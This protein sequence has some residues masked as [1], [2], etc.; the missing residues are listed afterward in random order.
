M[1][2]APGTPSRKAALGSA[3]LKRNAAAPL[4]ATAIL[5]CLGF[6][7][8]QLGHGLYIKAK[9]EVAQVLLERAWQKT[10]HDGKTH[11]AW[12]W[13]DA[14]P[15]AKLEMPSLSSSQIV[16]SNASGEAL[17]FGP[18]H[19]SGS[20]LPGGNGTAVIAGHRDTHF[21]I[22]NGLKNDDVVIVTIPDRSRHRYTVGG[23]KVVHKDYSQINPHA[24]RGLALVTCYPL[25]TT[26]KGPMR[27]VV[28]ASETSDQ[29]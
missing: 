3:L 26:T 17:A 4:W 11:K 18:G 9:A 19:L 28:F 10:L 12:P 21:S 7:T 5:L 23:T 8:W 6:G 27:Y 16:L 24:G 25:N 29:T 15:V 14:W 20:P 2:A 1:D 22:L 13:A